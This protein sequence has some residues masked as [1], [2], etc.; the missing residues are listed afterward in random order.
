MI[1]TRIPL[2][3]ETISE[4]G[5]EKVEHLGGLALDRRRMASSRTEVHAHDYREAAFDVDLDVFKY[6]NLKF[7]PCFCSKCKTGELGYRLQS[8]QTKRNHGISDETRAASASTT[9]KRRLTVA[10]DPTISTLNDG[11]PKRPRL[12]L[13]NDEASP[14]HRSPPAVD[15]TASARENIY[16]IDDPALSADFSPG[17]ARSVTSDG[18]PP[19]QS[20]PDAAPAIDIPQIAPREVFQIP[21]LKEHPE[22][23]LAYLN[24]VLGNVARGFT[25]V[26]AEWHLE[27]MLGPIRRIPG[28]ITPERPIPAKTLKTV[29]RRMRLDPDEFIE[30]YPVCDT[31]YRVYSLAE[32]DAANSSACLENKCKGHFF[33]RN[34]ESTNG[35]LAI[36]KVPVKIL[37]YSSPI[38]T[39]RRFLA[40]P[41]FAQMLRDSRGD[42]GKEP[43]PTSQKMYDVYDGTAWSE[44]EVG[45]ERV[46]ND[47]G[48]D[49]TARDLAVHP[50]SRLKIT[51][52]RY[53]LRFAVNLDW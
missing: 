43:I 47:E 34:H 42:N 1:Y 14:S 2:G 16:H 50:T 36:R 49:R 26:D 18:D 19:S 30:K 5:P 4:E 44:Q 11:S 24:A 53:G 35:V 10:N 6:S 37:P 27:T 46:I 3:S 15:H 13:A 12:E 51:E 41:G 40:R 45:L 20:Y 52:F 17:P 29:R 9:S 31:C 39:V 8:R 23:R 28:A 38:K 32:I 25:E 22:V 33:K 21:A 48:G 7:E